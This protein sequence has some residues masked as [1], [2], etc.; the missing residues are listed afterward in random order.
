MEKFF[1]ELKGNKQK[2]QLTAASCMKTHGEAFFAP[3]SDENG[4]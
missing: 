4:D 2:K 3:F 1:Y